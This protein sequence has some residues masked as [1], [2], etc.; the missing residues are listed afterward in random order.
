[1][2]NVIFQYCIPFNGSGLK[3]KEGAYYTN[4][5]PNSWVKKSTELFR[6]YA[7]KHNA[8]HI[9][10]QDRFVN[11]SSDYFE[12]IRLFKDPQ[13]DKYDKMLFVDVDVIPVNSNVNIFDID[14]VDVAGWPEHHFDGIE[15]KIRWKDQQLQMKKRFQAFGTDIVDSTIAGGMRMINSGVML[16][17]KDAR[18]RARQLFDDH[19]AW[20]NYQNCILDRKWKSSGPRTHCLDQPYFN[21]MFNKYD[22]NILELKK[23]WNRFPTKDDNMPCN[24]AHYVGKYK[25]RILKKQVT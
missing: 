23:E 16:W 7:E 15:V 24:F 8:K 25:D 22:Y 9:F 1:M 18:L 3:N 2:K 14:V 21:A 6:Q 10:L 12:A 13:F 20:Y 4:A 5:G 11:A 17:S 19:E